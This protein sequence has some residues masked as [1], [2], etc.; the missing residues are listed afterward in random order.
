MS[1]IFVTGD[2]HFGHA[3]AIPLFGRPLPPGD[4]AAMDEMLIDGINAVVG[5]NDRLIHVGDFTGPLPWKGRERRKSLETVR[6]LRSKIRCRRVELVV[7]NHDPSPRIARTIFED[8]RHILS[9]RGW[10][11][12]SDRIV[13]FHYPLRSWQGALR[14]AMHL[15]G[16]MH[17]AFEPI[18]RSMDVGVDCWSMRPIPL[19]DA[20]AALARIA[21]PPRPEPPI[22]R[23]PQ[24]A[25]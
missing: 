20:L 25:L 24:R 13:I 18:G 15:Y 3:E 8:A 5:R 6:R 22:A 16:H 23:V 10:S 12:G 21:P 11:G 9:W 19:D 14:G 1:K 4:V 17:G 2:T 7:G